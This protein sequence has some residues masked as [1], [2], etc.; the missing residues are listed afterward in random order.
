[1]DQSAPTLPSMID[2]GANAYGIDFRELVDNVLDVV[3]VTDATLDSPGPYIRYVNPAFTRLTGWRPEEVFGRSPRIL[4]GPGTS[5]ETL[6]D[7]GTALRAGKKASER[8]LNYT[9]SGSPYWA[10]MSIVP[11]LDQ[12]GR[13]GFFAGVV[14]DVTFDKFRTDELEQLADRDALTS[15]LNRRALLRNAELAFN[16]HREDQFCLAW[17]DIDHF[18]SVND[19]Y[20]HPVGDAV[21]IGVA[22][23]LTRNVRRAELIGRMG[24]EEFAIG[25]PGMGIAEARAFAERLRC[26]IADTIFP[27]ASGPIQVSC[28]IGIASARPA[29]SLPQ[30]INRADTALYEA[31]RQG[32]NRLEI[33]A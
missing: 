22:D 21:L 30:L 5:K 16:A 23:T 25:L 2:R 17:L 26:A 31:K 24:G 1:V 29:D 19:N 13:T 6:A 20:G 12:R 4:Q 7:L 28:S 10:D 3:M 27:T 32:R 15:V 18:K 33:V 11:M 9:K 14:R 8:V